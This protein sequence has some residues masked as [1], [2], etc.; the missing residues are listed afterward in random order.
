MEEVEEELVLA[1]DSTIV[2]L[3]QT[4]NIPDWVGPVMLPEFLFGQERA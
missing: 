2:Q 4:G 1:K 3:L